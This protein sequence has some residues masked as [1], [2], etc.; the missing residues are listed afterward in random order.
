MYENKLEFPGGRG[1]GG[2]KQKPSVGGVWIFSGT[3]HWFAILC[4]CLICH[5]FSIEFN[6]EFSLL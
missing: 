1:E 3:A 6:I 5:T 4:E 2:A